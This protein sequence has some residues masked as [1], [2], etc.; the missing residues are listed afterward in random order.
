MS[1]HLVISKA[2]KTYALGF[3][4]SRKGRKGARGQ[5]MRRG[6]NRIKAGRLF[7]TEILPGMETG[8]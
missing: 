6:I 8:P 5:E 3:R 1:I 2:S 4:G 7:S